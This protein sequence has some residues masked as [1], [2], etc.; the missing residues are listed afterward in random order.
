MSNRSVHHLKTNPEVRFQSS[1][2]SRNHGK[3]EVEKRTPNQ[4]LPVQ[5]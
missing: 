5:S 4:H 2:S 3:Y 1:M